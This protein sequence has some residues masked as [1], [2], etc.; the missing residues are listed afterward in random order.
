MT[1]EFHGDKFLVLKKGRRYATPLLLSLVAVEVSDV[2]FAVGL[3][4]GDLR[5]H[6]GSV[7]SYSLRTFSRS[8]VC[9]SLYFVLGGIITKFAYLKVGLSFVLIFVGGKMLLMD[10]YK[11]P[12]TAS[13]ACIAGILGLSIV[14]S[15]IRSEA[16]R[17]D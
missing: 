15:V 13:L 3:H 10:V 2:I 14:V 11:L 7:S 5:R 9:R 16:P 1:P 6:V 8:S 12:I 17:S 4:T